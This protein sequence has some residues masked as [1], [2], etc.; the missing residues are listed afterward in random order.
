METQRWWADNF[1][2]GQPAAAG[3][4]FKAASAKRVR[5]PFPPYVEEP[6]SLFGA[7]RFRKIVLFKTQVHFCTA[8]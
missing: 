5:I 6:A 7:G 1:R 8:Q 4:Y 2:W 3:A